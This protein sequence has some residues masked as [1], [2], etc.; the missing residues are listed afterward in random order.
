MSLFDSVN[1]E[2][3]IECKCGLKLHDFQTKDFDNFLEQYIINEDGTI[4]AEDYNLKVIPKEER[5]TFGFPIF[6]KELLGFYKMQITDTIE[7][8]TICG[9][10]KCFIS[11]IL[12]FIDGKIA[13]KKI[14]IKELE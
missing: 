14:E 4:D 8:H 2:E 12:T 3:G 6:K 9:K 13:N 11:M 1:Y 7:C 5:D 10:G